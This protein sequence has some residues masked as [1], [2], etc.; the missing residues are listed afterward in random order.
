MRILYLAHRFPYPPTFGSTVRSFHCI[1]HLAE[2]HEVTVMAPVRSAQE[3]EEAAGIG[4]YCA[5]FRA[6]PVSN[7]LQV[8]K[9]GLTVPTPVTASEAYFDSGAMRDAV[10][11]LLREGRIDM[12]MAFS[13][14]IGR[15]L[16]GAT[17]V[18]RLMDFCDVDSRKWLEYARFK[19][20]P[21]SLGFRWEGV[22]LQGVERRLSGEFDLVTV[23]TPG[24]LEALRE[25]GIDGP[26]DWF[27]NGVDTAAFTPSPGPYEEDTICFL[28][29]MD[30]FPNEQAMA[31][32]CAD[33]LPLLR[34]R[35]PALRLLIVGADPSAG[36]RQLGALPGVTVTGSVPKVQPFVQRSALTIAPLQIARGTQNK[37]LESMAMGVPVVASRVAAAGVDAVAGE[38]LLAASTPREYADAIL[39]VLENPSERARLAAAGR[40]RVLSHHSWPSAMTRLDAAIER[41]IELHAARRNIPERRAA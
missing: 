41:C 5:S 12:A 9:M 4:K 39:R 34:A 7:A 24:E 40:A 30:Y 21:A 26:A 33:V 36:V 20:W 3:A 8:V 14:S 27:P 38:H 22:R 6:F 16:R 15:V 37:L 29:R 19:P 28:G 1:R 17:R 25:S 11:R 13:S 32:F 10:S 2:R 23:A 35:R 18:P 31:S